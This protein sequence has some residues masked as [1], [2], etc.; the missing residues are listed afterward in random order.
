[1]DTPLSRKFYPSGSYIPLFIV[2]LLLDAYRPYGIIEKLDGPSNCDITGLMH[3]M[4]T[5]SYWERG[6]REKG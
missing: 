4:Y 3:V 5:S 2:E 1:M 6:T